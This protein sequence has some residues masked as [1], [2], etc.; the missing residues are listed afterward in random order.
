MVGMN[1]GITF[2]LK[3]VVVPEL[4]RERPWFVPCKRAKGSD[5]RVEERQYRP[6]CFVR[7]GAGLDEAPFRV[8]GGACVCI[9]F[10]VQFELS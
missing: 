10:R 4:R 1:N 7:Q 2:G 5:D 3:T 8:G 9:R 6:V